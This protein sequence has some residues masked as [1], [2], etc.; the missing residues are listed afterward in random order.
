MKPRSS[1]SSEAFAMGTRWPSQAL[2][3]P[4]NAIECPVHPMLP[5]G[6]LSRLAVCYQGMREH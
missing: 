5:Q 2:A 4:S 3:V 6:L 1:T